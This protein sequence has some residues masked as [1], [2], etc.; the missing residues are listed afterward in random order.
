MGV[1]Q[2]WGVSSHTYLNSIPHD[3]KKNVAPLLELFLE[4]LAHSLIMPEGDKNLTFV[5]NDDFVNSMTLS[6]T[7]VGK[8]AK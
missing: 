1:V 8:W 7:K 3:S 6:G 4:P 5:D 2:S